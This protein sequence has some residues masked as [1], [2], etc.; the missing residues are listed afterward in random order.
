MLRI[1][2]KDLTN[3]VKNKKAQLYLLNFIKI[4]TQK[5]IIKYFDACVAHYRTLYNQDNDILPVTAVTAVALSQ[6]Q[7]MRLTSK[8]TQITGKTAELTNRVDPSCLGGVRLDYDGKCIDGSVTHRLDTIRDLL[9][10]T[11]L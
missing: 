8:L 9:K 3:I 2:K 5:G 11:V 1:I 7:C 10:N 6:E 4:L